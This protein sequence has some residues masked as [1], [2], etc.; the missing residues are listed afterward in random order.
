MREGVG[1]HTFLYLASLI[2]SIDGF[3]M[4][5]RWSTGID[6]TNLCFRNCHFHL[7]R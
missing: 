2:T 6:T 4:D 7:Y 5:I 1:L 3:Y